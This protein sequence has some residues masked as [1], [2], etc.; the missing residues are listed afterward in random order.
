M[1]MIWTKV[2]SIFFL[3]LG[4]CQSQHEPQP[5]EESDGNRILEFPRKYPLGGGGFTEDKVWD[6]D[7]PSR[8]RCQHLHL[9]LRCK[10][11]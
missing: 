5:P 8:S 2:A 4:S 10:G 3:V 9:S 7:Y 11:K 6:Y 1:I